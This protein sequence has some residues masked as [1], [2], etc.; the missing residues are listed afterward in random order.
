MAGALVCVCVGSADGSGT[1]DLMRRLRAPPRALDAV[2]A[3]ILVQQAASPLA[4]A[5][6]SARTCSTLYT[7]LLAVITAHVCAIRA[8]RCLTIAR[9]TLP[10][11]SL[12]RF[13]TSGIHGYFLNVCFLFDLMRSSIVHDRRLPRPTTGPGTSYY[14]S[15]ADLCHREI[16]RGNCWVTAGGNCRG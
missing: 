2:R 8:R 7:L 6:P 15:N 12:R 11:H 4:A 3:Q 16:P 5:D 13:F 10:S 9:E 14:S 1:G